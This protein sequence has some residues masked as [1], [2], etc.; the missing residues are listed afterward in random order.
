[1]Y[2]NIFFLN[3]KILSINKNLKNNKNNYIKK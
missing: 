2:F 3:T 1:M